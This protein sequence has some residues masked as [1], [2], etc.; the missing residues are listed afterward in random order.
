MR[1]GNE[2]NAIDCDYSIAAGEAITSDRS[3]RKRPQPAGEKVP[4]KCERSDNAMT[5]N[6]SEKNASDQEP[7]R[8]D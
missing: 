1:H 8:S 5:S 6:E 4:K 3:P 2:P 7:V